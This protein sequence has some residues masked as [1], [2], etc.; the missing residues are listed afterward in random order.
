ML[1]LTKK[2]YKIKKLFHVKYIKTYE[3]FY[4]EHFIFNFENIENLK[5][6]KETK[7]DAILLSNT[8]KKKKDILEDNIDKKKLKKTRK[9]L[10]LLRNRLKNFDKI[11]L[12]RPFYILYKNIDCLSEVE[13]INIL[14][15][16]IKNRKYYTLKE[17][18]NNNITNKNNYIN[19]NKYLNDI[20]YVDIYP[21]E[22]KEYDIYSLEKENESS[23]NGNCI[24]TEQNGNYI[25]NKN[26]CLDNINEENVSYIDNKEEN[27]R[28]LSNKN[29]RKNENDYVYKLLFRI[30]KKLIRNKTVSNLDILHI[31]KLSYSLNF[32]KIN[33]HNF[34]SL[35]LS[36]FLKKEI[37]IILENKEECKIK[38]D[39]ELDFLLNLLIIENKNLKTYF[40]NLLYDYLFAIIKNDL[41]NLSYKNVCLLLNINNFEKNTYDNFFF[42][43]LNKNKEIKKKI[44]LTDINYFFFYQIKNNINLP[45][46]DD[47]IEECVK[48]N[49]NSKLIQN[50]HLLSLLL[51]H[52]N[53][54][55]CYFSIYDKYVEIVFNMY[56]YLIKNIKMF[57]EN[58]R[59]EEEI[60]NIKFLISF[61]LA[62]SLIRNNLYLNEEFYI[63]ILYLVN[64]KEL[65][66]DDL[67]ILLNFIIFCNFKNDLYYKRNLL[68]CDKK[69]IT[70]IY[71]GDKKY[72][73]FDYND[74]SFYLYE[75]L[76][77]NYLYEE[78]KYNKNEILKNNEDKN[79]SSLLK[80]CSSENKKSILINYLSNKNV[81]DIFRNNLDK[82]K[83]QV[84]ENDLVKINRL[85]D[86]FEI[87]L[88]SFF[89]KKGEIKKNKSY[90]LSILD[91][92][93]SLRDNYLDNK[94]Y[95]H[96]LNLFHKNI[97]NY[98]INI[99]DLDKILFTYSHLNLS[100][101]IISLNILNIIEKL[102]TNFTRNNYC[103]DEEKCFFDS[104]CSILLSISELNLSNIID[105]TFFEKKVLENI[106]KV[107]INSVLILLQ[108]FILKGNS[109]L[110]IKV[111]TLLLLEYIKKK[112]YMVDNDMNDLNKD[113]LLEKLRYDKNYDFIKQY[114]KENKNYDK[115]E[116]MEEAKEKKK[117]Y[118][119]TYDKKKKGYD[120]INFNYYFKKINEDDV[121]EFLF[122]RFVFLNIILNS[123]ILLDNFIFYDMN[124]FKEILN[125]FNKIIYIMKENFSDILNINLKED[126]EKYIISLNEEI[127]NKNI[128]EVERKRL[129]FNICN[130]TNE[131][132]NNK[133]DILNKKDFFLIINYFLFIFKFD[134]K[135]II[136]DK[137]FLE[138]MKLQH[139]Y[140]KKFKIIYYNYKYLFIYRK[141][142]LSIIYDMKKKNCIKNNY[143]LDFNKNINSHNE[144]KDINEFINI[145]R[146]FNYLCL[147]KEI[148]NNV[149]YNYLKSNN[150]DIYE[151]KEYNYDIIDND[152]I[153][154]NLHSEILNIYVNV[155]FFNY[156]IPLVI[157]MKD[158]CLAIKILFSSSENV[159]TYNVLFSIMKN[160]LK[161]YNYDV[162]LIKS[163]I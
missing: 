101:D 33:T 35:Y 129:Y 81:N 30:N 1:N 143:I 37:K 80:K 127:E 73:L 121:Y 97:I 85:E 105:V 75:N 67:I 115:R 92:L 134:L 131:Q 31:Y 83:D 111:I 40:F 20:S 148:S 93:I 54:S 58:K 61:S 95:L 100:K 17:Q 156:I 158:K 112:Y 107:N 14:Y 138:Y 123:N 77:K 149:F 7:E 74:L 55:K 132:I 25:V 28:N 128:K 119:F 151:N 64:N 38:N 42:L 79:K 11:P 108:Y 96:L 120:N 125:N 36:Y 10:A 23:H 94:F 45:F 139:L 110:N 102:K 5:K 66:N 150:I 43:V 88:Q 91:L 147:K 126:D 163:K 122:L 68:Y 39:S 90:Y 78:T 60:L 144:K 19:N 162:I 140:T 116:E 89:E 136:K 3:K 118:I 146:Y 82:N 133:Y 18:E 34:I 53:Y 114:L 27:A 44:T 84:Q 9:V 109:F 46:F 56:S 26:N 15:S 159:D 104:L 86:K 152:N 51:L 71:D 141:L 65:N 21:V 48:S 117:D 145:L 106:N 124:N 63:F 8:Q 13:I 12:N 70:Y 161:N 52:Y 155:P 113:I 49:V 47:L 99:F 16:A 160:F 29:V 154:Y 76:K 57:L 135:F 4:N 2:I 72:I 41:F 6:L 59:I 87:K 142:I 50:I 32:Y 137:T 22:T 153:I 62:L 103:I 130:N 98:N 24:N 157:K 69:K